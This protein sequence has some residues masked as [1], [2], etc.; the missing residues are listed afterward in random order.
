MFDALW[1]LRLRWRLWLGTTGL[2]LVTVAVPIWWQTA[3][4]AYQ[5]EAVIVVEVASKWVL[6]GRL[7]SVVVARATWLRAGESV[8]AEGQANSEL[9]RVIGTAQAA[10]RAVAIANGVIGTLL[11]ELRADAARRQGM[12]E[13]GVTLTRHRLE[14]EHRAVEAELRKLPPPNGLPVPAGGTL[15]VVG[16]AHPNDVFRVALETRYLELTKTLAAL[17]PPASGAAPGITVLDPAVVATALPVPIAP[18]R[19]AVVASLIL[20][21]LLPLVREWWRRELAQRRGGES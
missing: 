9:V 12:H 1:T 3:P 17:A 10:P 6:L 7:N 2:L 11:S 21:A 5:A 13:V 19:A 18:L 20:G 14:Q 15:V 8:R 4:P 16:D